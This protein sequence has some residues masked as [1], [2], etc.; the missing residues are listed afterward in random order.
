MSKLGVTIPSAPSTSV[1]ACCTFSGRGRGSLRRYSIRAARALAGVELQAETINW[2]PLGD[3]FCSYR[4]EGLTDSAGKFRF[5]NIRIRKWTLGPPPKE[6]DHKAR[7]KY[8]S[9]TVKVEP[10][11][12]RAWQ[13]LGIARYYERDDKGAV[14]ALEQAGFKDVFA[15]IMKGTGHGI[16]PDGLSVALAFMR[17][18]LGL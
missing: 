7:E 11:N 3:P 8:F 14:E 13:Q 2:N 4:P 16:A 5:S 10:K 12:P 1:S 9:E 17:D 15:H 6:N 18:K